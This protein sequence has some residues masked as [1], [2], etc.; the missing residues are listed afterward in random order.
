M[1]DDR[2]EEAAGCEV[3]DARVADAGDEQPGK[4]RA[5][6]RTECAACGDH[7]EQ[8][9][10]LTAVEELE[11]EAPEDRHQEQVQH[12]DPDIEEHADPQITRIGLEGGADRRQRQ[13]HHPVD[14][15]Q[16]QAAAD[17]ADQPSIERHGEDREYRGVR[18]KIGD[19][20]CAE[21]CGDRLAHRTHREITAEHEEEQQERRDHHSDLARL[22]L[23]EA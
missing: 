7:T 23:R 19:P 13:R 16:Q 4:R 21:H 1:A 18:P 6:E 17:L 15:G 3:Q 20:I 2:G 9:A 11:Q 12:A 14:A 22:D 8:A 5:D 10:R